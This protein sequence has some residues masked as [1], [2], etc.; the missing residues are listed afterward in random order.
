[1]S[2]LAFDFDIEQVSV[3]APIPAGLKFRFEPIVHVEDRCANCGAR[4]SHGWSVVE[5]AGR[6]WSVCDS[7]MGISFE[8]RHG[9][10]PVR[11][12][13]S[14]AKGWRIGDAISVARPH[15]FGN[16]FVIGTLENGGNITREVAVVEFRKA[17]VERRL[18]FSIADVRRQLAG[19]DLACWCALDEVCHA[20]V[21]LQFANGRA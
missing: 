1:M 17:L 7:C 13:L 3:S 15:R 11:L 21:L 12:Q 6:Q 10:M 18:Q 19:K 4:N 9:R 14:R 8:Q 20:D 2:Q 16:P 5:H